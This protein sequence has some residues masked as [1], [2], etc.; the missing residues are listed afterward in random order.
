MCRQR[1]CVLQGIQR[2]RGGST[3]SAENRLTAE[4]LA[5]L[6]A[7]DVVTIE[8]GHEFGRRRH[9][10]GTVARVEGPCLYVR[11]EGTRGGVFVERYS[12]RDGVRIG[13]GTRAELVS[14]DPD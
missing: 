13:G 12:L 3:L 4:Q 2:S 10:I 8:S 1:L 6:A 9:V 7:G 14:G 5:A 11:C